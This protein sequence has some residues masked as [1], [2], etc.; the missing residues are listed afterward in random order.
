MKRR[1]EKTVSDGG[2]V[3]INLRKVRRG[4]RARLKEIA[5]RHGLTLEGLCLDALEYVAD[6]GKPIRAGGEALGGGNSMLGSG[7]VVSVCSHARKRRYGAISRGDGGEVLPMALIFCLD[8]GKQ[9]LNDRAE[10]L[11]EETVA[12]GGFTEVEGGSAGAE[13]AGVQSRGAGGAESVRRIHAT[14]LHGE[15]GDSSDGDNPRLDQKTAQ[16]SAKEGTV[17]DGLPRSEAGNEVGAAGRVEQGDT[18]S[19]E[20]S[21]KLDGTVELLKGNPGTPQADATGEKEGVGVYDGLACSG[22]IADTYGGISRTYPDGVPCPLPGCLSHVTHPCEG[23]GRIA[24]YPVE[25]ESREEFERDRMGQTGADNA[26]KMVATHSHVLSSA[27]PTPRIVDT[28][29]QV[30]SILQMMRKA[31]PKGKKSAGCPECGSLRGVHA[32]GCSKR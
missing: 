17:S 2:L 4:L 1:I 8:C 31:A 7:D 16:A 15:R 26:A 21:G 6:T 11:N 5:D 22:A 13:Q 10:G 19:I 27:D 25:G 32:K 28:A 29:A 9:L 18:G 12:V 23:C 24:G 3:N 30:P 20:R 14:I